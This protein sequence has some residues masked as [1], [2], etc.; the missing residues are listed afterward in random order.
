MKRHVSLQPLSRDHY[1]GL[2]QAERLSEAAAAE[3]ADA[4][5]AA[6]EGFARAWQT[7]I[8]DHFRVEERLLLPL[9]DDLPEDTDAGTAAAA[10][11]RGEHA[12]LRALAHEVMSA[13]AAACPDGDVLR[14]LGRDLHD[15]IRWEE[16]AL[17]PLLERTLS[18]EQLRALEAPLWEV[19]MS[20]PRAHPR[21]VA[22]ERERRVH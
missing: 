8:S 12:A 14:R 4:R 22:G 6:A 13:A 11:L 3:G 10:R 19:E 1:G 21:A 18:A 7:E 17:F 20:R 15:H 2:V 5:R 9:L 16:R